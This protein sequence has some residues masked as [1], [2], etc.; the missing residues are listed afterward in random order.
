MPFKKFVLYQ[1]YSFSKIITCPKTTILIFLTILSYT[2]AFLSTPSY[3]R[4]SNTHDQP[5]TTPATTS[6]LLTSQK[7]RLPSG[8][9]ARTVQSRRLRLHAARLRALIIGVEIIIARHPR[10]GEFRAR[11]N[12]IFL[13]SARAHTA[14]EPAPGTGNKVVSACERESALTFRLIVRVCGHGWD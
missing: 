12:G 7:R 14:R 9:L 4:P 10:G 11:Y 6:L 13:V 2:L 3:H 8:R 1:T 5:L